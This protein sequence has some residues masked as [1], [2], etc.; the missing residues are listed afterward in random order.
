VPLENVMRPV[1]DETSIGL[2][3]GE[4]D[5]A[6]EADPDEEGPTDGDGVPD[7][8]EQA[9]SPSAAPAERRSRKAG[10]DVIGLAPVS[11]P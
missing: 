3:A 9:A 8:D 6:G 4:R 10:R 11:P 2:D 5:A 1:S 7:P